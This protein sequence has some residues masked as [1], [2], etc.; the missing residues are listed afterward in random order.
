MGTPTLLL[1]GGDSPLFYRAAIETLKKSILNSRIAIM[2]GQRHAAMDT[3]PELF[4]SKVI[5]FLNEKK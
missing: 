2:P 1:L 4:L 5:G 3:A